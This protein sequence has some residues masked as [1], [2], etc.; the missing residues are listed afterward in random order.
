MVQPIRLRGRDMN[1]KD[2]KGKTIGFAASGGLD[3]CT[4]THWLTQQG[5]KVVCFT[6]DLAQP[7]ETDFAAIEKRMR[8]CGAVDF[9]GVPLQNEIAA[10]GMAV[11]QAQACYEGR[12]W[13]TTGIGRQ[14]TTTGLLKEVVKRGIGILAHGCT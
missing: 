12:Y 13:N 2:L 8:A 1:V 7:D 9:V 14:V 4:I 10:G 5:V 3:S 6:A 11:V